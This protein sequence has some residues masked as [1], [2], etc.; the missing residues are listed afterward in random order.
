[1]SANSCLAFLSSFFVVLKLLISNFVKQKGSSNLEHIF[2]LLLSVKDF[3]IFLPRKPVEHFLKI[4]DE[5]SLKDIASIAKKLISSPLTMASHG[6][7]MP[8]FHHTILLWISSAYFGEV[9]PNISIL[10]WQSFVFRATTQ[11]AASSVRNEIAP[12]YFENGHAQT[13]EFVLQ[14]YCV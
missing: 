5:V 10:L 1:M 2:H 7:S 12:C 9:F 8:L 3:T 4:V 14:V 13:F 6:D 11:S